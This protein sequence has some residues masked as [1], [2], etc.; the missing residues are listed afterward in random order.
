MSEKKDKGSCLM[1]PGRSPGNLVDSGVG[2][3]RKGRAPTEKCIKSRG[4]LTV[5]PL[6]KGSE[7]FV[8]IRG[9]I[10]EPLTW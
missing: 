9:N 4:E 5:D 3:H 2:P 10:K 8:S 6:R 1:E 7:S